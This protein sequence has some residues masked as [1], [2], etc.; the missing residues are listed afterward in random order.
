MKT[1]Q[2]NAVPKDI[3]NQSLHTSFKRQVPLVSKALDSSAISS[4]SRWIV[5]VVVVIYNQK[6][7]R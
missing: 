4:N 2:K 5:V 3:Q 7:P 1:M 6:S